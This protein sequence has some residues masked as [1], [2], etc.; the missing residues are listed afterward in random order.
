MM[1]VLQM[2][3]PRHGGTHSSDQRHMTGHMTRQGKGWGSP[4]HCVPGTMMCFL[5]SASPVTFHQPSEWEALTGGPKES[6]V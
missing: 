5:C 2:G 4:G 6:G 1:P 3:K